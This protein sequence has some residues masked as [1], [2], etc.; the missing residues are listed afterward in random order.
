M[1]SLRIAELNFRPE[2]DSYLGELTRTSNLKID[3]Y[4]IVVGVTEGWIYPGMLEALKT[5]VEA[6]G[7]DFPV[8]TLEENGSTVRVFGLSN[9]IKLLRTLS[10]CYATTRVIKR[11]DSANK[12]KLIARPQAKV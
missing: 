5:P 7:I 11:A 1:R 9:V 8:A 10:P 2:L 4:S 3:R 6:G 12:L